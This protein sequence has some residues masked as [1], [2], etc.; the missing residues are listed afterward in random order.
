MLESGQPQQG[1]EQFELALKLDPHDYEALA[2]M[3][4]AYFALGNDRDAVRYLE[5]AEREDA[6]RKRHPGEA[7]ETAANETEEGQVTQD[8][9]IAQATLALDPHRP[10][11]RPMERAARAIRA[12][13]VAEMRIRSCASEHGIALPQPDVSLTR[14]TH[15]ASDDLAEAAL[16]RRIEQLDPF[17]EF[18]FQMESSATENCGPPDDPTNAAIAR[19]GARTQ[20]HP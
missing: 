10:G 11:S 20:A 8:L 4:Q 12:Y 7:T 1:L 5:S 9:A 16:A 18:V 13:D 19:I 17:M 6:Q 3:G 15:A 14:F 2:G